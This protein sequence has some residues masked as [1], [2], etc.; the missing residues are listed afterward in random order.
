LHLFAVYYSAL[1]ELDDLAILAASA[2]KRFAIVTF[3]GA[4][5]ARSSVFSIP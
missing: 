3:P 5:N 4:S 2:D 1:T